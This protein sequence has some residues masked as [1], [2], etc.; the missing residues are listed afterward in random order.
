PSGP[1][2]RPRGAMAFGLRAQQRADTVSRAGSASYAKGVAALQAG[3]ASYPQAVAAF[4]AAIA[5]D[6]RAVLPRARLVEA[7]YDAWQATA[8]ESWL[9]R[10]AGGHAP[11][12]GAGRRSAFVPPPRRGARP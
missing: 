11:R 12:G 1:V 5:A 6:P 8:D 10:G 3:T 7:Y 9:R 2:L 4:E